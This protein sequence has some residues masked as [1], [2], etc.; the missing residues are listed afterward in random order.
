MAH[1]VVTVRLPLR[2]SEVSI[3]FEHVCML[4]AV[5]VGSVG[6]HADEQT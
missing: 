3:A 5:D 1:N 4:C 2:V 6:L